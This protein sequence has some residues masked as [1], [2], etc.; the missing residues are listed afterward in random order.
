M[1]K[2]LIFSFICFLSC[3]FLTSVYATNDVDYTL[4]ITKDYEF[5]ETI[6]YSLSD[7]KQINNG[8][9]YF[10]SIVNDDIY[11]DIFYNTK[12]KKTKKL[13]TERKQKPI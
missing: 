7:Y 6:N 2:R 3:F 12:Y 1:K 4:T 13:N 8:Y 9:N 11:T 10:Y 5:K